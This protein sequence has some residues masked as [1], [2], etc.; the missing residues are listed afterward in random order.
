M[1]RLGDEKKPSLD[2]RLSGGIVDD[3]RFGN[4][5]KIHHG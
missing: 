1:Y 3:S 5:G 4:A 2:G